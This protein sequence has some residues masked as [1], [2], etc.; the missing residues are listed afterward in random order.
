MGEEDERLAGKIIYGFI[1][2]LLVPIIENLKNIAVSEIKIKNSSDQYKNI[3]TRNVVSVE[4][5]TQ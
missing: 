3:F 1:L 5:T 4:L 2:D